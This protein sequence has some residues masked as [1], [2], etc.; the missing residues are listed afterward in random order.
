[1]NFLHGVSKIMVELPGCE[2]VE[3]RARIPPNSQLK[4]I[5][6]C[7]NGL[8]ASLQNSLSRF[9]SDTAVE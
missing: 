7:Q 9:D 2:P 3:M 8:C 5:G 4:Y 6:S 1:M